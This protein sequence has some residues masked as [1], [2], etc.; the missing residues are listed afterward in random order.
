MQ[1]NCFQAHVFSSIR[2]SNSI[3]SVHAAFVVIQTNPPRMHH[4]V[5]HT[6]TLTSFVWLVPPSGANTPPTPF[7]VPITQSSLKHKRS[8]QP[9]FPLPR[10]QAG[11]QPLHSFSIHLVTWAPHLPP[12]HPFPSKS[13]CPT[14]KSLSRNTR[15]LL[16]IPGRGRGN[17]RGADEGCRLIIGLLE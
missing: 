7:A 2:Q 1:S 14:E 12:S 8:A 10:T 16:C 6:P 3:L 5:S 11:M 4:A 15:H 9:S 17:C 13:A